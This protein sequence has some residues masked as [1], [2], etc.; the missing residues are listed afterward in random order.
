MTKKFKS[1]VCNKVFDIEDSRDFHDS[2]HIRNTETET[3][4]YHGK[5]QVR[6]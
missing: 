6:D 1:E 4:G 3:W 5:I 2:M